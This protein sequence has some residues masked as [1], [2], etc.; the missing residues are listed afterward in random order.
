MRITEITAQKLEQ[1]LGF[2]EIP[3]A[4]VILA[5]HSVMGME[6]QL[7]AEILGCEPSDIT[8]AESDPI[9]KA[10][11]AFIAGRYANQMA[12]QTAGWDDAEDIALQNLLK[13]L[14][15]E[16]DG[17]FLLRVAAVA[18]KAQR[19]TRTPDR[20]LD[21]SAHNGATVIT[22]TQRLVS[23]INGIG[24]KSTEMT[25]QLSIKDGS[26][27]NPSFEEIDGLLSVRGSNKLPQ[28]IELRAKRVELSPEE[29]I[30]SM[31]GI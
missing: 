18:N 30:D 31:T 16:K 1:E 5:K 15:F 14:P 24:D 9:Y 13:R 19:R 3:D 25:R 21:P 29:L 23:R 2:P 20:V 28:D 27:S 7:I 6:N 22:L 4:Y 10:V 8:E 26:M 11:R 17:D 12:N